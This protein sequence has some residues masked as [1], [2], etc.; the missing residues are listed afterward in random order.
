MLLPLKNISPQANDVDP[1]FLVPFAS[2]IWA[3]DQE[4]VLFLNA[5]LDA[6]ERSLEAGWALLITP[7]LLIAVRKLEAAPVSGIT[8]LDDALGKVKTRAPVGVV[9]VIL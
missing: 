9:P 8:L 5:T 4:L 3:A 7:P 1:R 6:S 2:G